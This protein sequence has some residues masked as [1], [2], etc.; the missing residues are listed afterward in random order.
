[1][2]EATS[3]KN[4]S[5]I[6]NN[7]IQAEILLEFIKELRKKHKRIVDY[8]K[9]NNGGENNNLKK[10]FIKESHEIIFK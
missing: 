6:T 5:F 3:M 9:C 2:D 7:S 4:S 1:L 10:L 8:I